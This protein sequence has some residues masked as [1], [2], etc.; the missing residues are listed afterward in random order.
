MIVWFLAAWGAEPDRLAL[1]ARLIADDHPDRAVEVLADFEP[2]KKERG[3]YH[4]L[5]GMAAFESGDAT[6]A[7]AQLTEAVAYE[8]P[9]VAWL[10]LAAA[11]EQ[12]GDLPGAL[13]ALAT[14]AI[15]ELPAAWVLR[16]RVRFGLDQ[17]DA[18][19]T[20]ISDG[21][22]RFPDHAGLRQERFRQLL[23]LQLFHQVA[24][25]A[26]EAL[27]GADEDRWVFVLDGLLEAPHEALAF[28]E[29]MLLVHPDSVRARVGLASACLALERNACAGAFLAEAAAW[30]P[31]YAV[32]AAECF[33]RDGD[34]HRA[35]YLN[36]L[37]VD[38][39]EKARQRLGLLI[40]SRSF[41]AASAL[42]ARITRLGLLEEEAVAYALA[43]AHA[44]TGRRERAEQLITR[45]TDPGFVRQGTALLESL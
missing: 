15:D 35:L 9:P 25:D 6:T 5:L 1:A 39:A 28:G 2:P 45:L 4:T 7:A 40:E 22:A 16:G 27:Q 36:S 33:R 18:A 30:E 3:R 17:H 13:D 29:A 8:V 44:Q 12:L 38:P 19:F 24:T 21:S 20:A 14:P 37:V 10:T 26:P 34:L 41:T 31:R 23:A 42:D 11:R 32:Q 43:Y